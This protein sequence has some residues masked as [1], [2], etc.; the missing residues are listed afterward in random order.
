MDTLDTSIDYT[1]CTRTTRNFC[2]TSK[3]GCY[4]LAAQVEGDFLSAVAELLVQPPVAW[5]WRV[6]RQQSQDAV[7]RIPLALAE[8]SY[9]AAKLVP[10]LLW[11]VLAVCAALTKA[12]TALR[13]LALVS[14]AL[15]AEEG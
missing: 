9:D 12:S 13:P 2:K 10:E 3:L 6:S 4:N 15:V 7:V 11:A 1:R 5:R 14:W 8:A